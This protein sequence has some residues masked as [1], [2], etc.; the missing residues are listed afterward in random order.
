MVNRKNSRLFYQIAV[1]NRKLDYLIDQEWC[2]SEFACSQI[3]PA[4]SLNN[5]SYNRKCAG[6]YLFS[7]AAASDCDNG[8]NIDYRVCL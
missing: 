4:P 3:A 6:L 5:G 8:N 7:P 1:K 2:G